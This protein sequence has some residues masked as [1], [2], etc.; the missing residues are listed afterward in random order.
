MKNQEEIMNLHAKSGKF[1]EIAGNFEANK[2][3][4]EFL[5]DEEVLIN[6][7][8]W[9]EEKNIEIQEMISAIIIQDFYKIKK[10][11]KK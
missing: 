8:K 11:L 1:G 5:Q 4:E 6:A 3:I 7:K 2:E 10:I 9:L